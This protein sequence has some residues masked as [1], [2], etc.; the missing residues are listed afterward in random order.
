MIVK[1]GRNKADIE[2]KPEK[3]SKEY[4]EYSLSGNSRVAI[5]WK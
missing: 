2:I 4:M 3:I 5:K 1:S